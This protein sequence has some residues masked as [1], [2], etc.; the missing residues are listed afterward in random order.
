MAR[1]TAMTVARLY[2]FDYLTDEADLDNQL[3][4]IALLGIEHC[5]IPCESLRGM[6]DQEGE[7][8]Y[9]PDGKGFFYRYDQDKANFI[10]GSDRLTKTEF[11]AVKQYWKKHRSK[12]SDPDYLVFYRAAADFYPF[13]DEGGNE[14]GYL[15]GWFKKKPYEG[16]ISSLPFNYGIKLDFKEVWD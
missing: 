4:D 11:K 1:D 13:F 14:K 6:G 7:L 8:V 5:Y 9:Y 3:L 12:G 15:R 2:I 16:W 10:A